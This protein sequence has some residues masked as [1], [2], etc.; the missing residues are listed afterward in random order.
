MASNRSPI[1]VLI[2]AYL[3]L[4]VGLIDSNAVNLALPA[5]QHDLGG[6]VSSAQW[7]ADAYNVTFAAALLTA[8]SLGDRFGRRRV[9]R[10]G[11]LAFVVAS[12]AC[13]LAPSLGVLLAARA[14]QGVGA[15]LMLPQGL[16]IA[17][18]VFPD[19]A[20]R[21]RATA[22]WAVAAAS[23]AA[24]G[25]IVG[26]VL[27]DS[28]GW[29]Y[30]F[31]LNAPIGVVALAMSFRYLPESRNPTAGKVD[32]F[33]QTLTML[34]LGTLTLVL[35]EGRMLGIVW[36]MALAL[37][38]AAGAAGLVWSQRR[39][40][41]P[42]LPPQF[43]GNRRLVIALVATFAM[44]FGTYGM[45]LVNSLAFQQ[46]RG[47]SAL[48]TAVAFLPMPLT[49]LALIPVANV[50]ARRSG[51]RL[52]MTSGLVL[53]GA[54]MS[55]Y[56]LV[57][58]G[59]ELWLLESAFVLAGAGLA[60]NTGPAVGM[61]MASAP[62]SRAGMTSGVVNLARL[63]GITVGVA[64]MGTVLALVGARAAVLTGGLAEL[65]GAVVV[66]GYTRSGRS[67]E[68]APKEESAMRELAELP[69]TGDADIAALAS[70]LA[71]PARC[72]VL[73]ALDD[74]RALPASVLADEAGV[75]R[76]TASSH[77]GKL[78]DAGFLTVQ[79]HGRHRYYR[80]AGPD[81]A[82]LL[83]RL[84]RLAPSRPVTSLRDGTRAARLRSARTCYDHLAGRLGVAVMG[85]LLERDVL[86]GGD[87]RYDP[88]L[89]RHDSPSN[90]G[91]DVDYELTSSGRSFLKDVGIE[92]PSGPRPVMRYCIDWTEQRH[93][94][95]GG[96]GAAVLDRFVSA[97]WI[98][99]S[100]RGRAVTVTDRGRAALANCFGIDW[101]D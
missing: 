58:P 30:I 44:T 68:T 62:V 100:P 76:S 52:P 46:Q 75:S 87:G 15:A 99:R 93:H 14:A 49:Y 21:A 9:L 50:L 97:H 89:H 74:G 26:G 70:L 64:V 56:A 41:N 45:L 48:A 84:G 78:T 69:A 57:G 7:T 11:L 10:T 79:T 98:K 60:M 12:L 38:V 29:R 24:L 83:E 101:A 40:T 35:V 34:T 66:F 61:A 85:S 6:G 18:A 23:S 25:P 3:G 65:L 31:W 51:P 59:A 28:L 90:P 95:A 91:H 72:K 96:L 71:D 86:V 17:A 37:V 77:L 19:A 92:L 5:I 80:L 20:G 27:T 13:A 39:V 4:F 88:R 33:G 67:Q 16:A 55:L 63:V 94:L 82:D 1:T 73:L 8:G 2:A 54:G 36:T 53:M 81:I 43:F 22:A 42:M 47:V 32:P